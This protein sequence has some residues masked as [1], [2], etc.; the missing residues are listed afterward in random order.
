MTRSP[1]QTGADECESQ[2]PR[3][4]RDA[5][6]K[7]KR[8]A[9]EVADLV[10]LDPDNGLGDD[11][12]KHAYLSEIQQ[13][14]RPGRAIVFI[15]FSGRI[16]KH[17]ALVQRLHDRLGGEVLTMRTSASVPTAK[18]GYAPRV[19]WFTVVGPDA[20]L[21]ARAQAFAV[22]LSSM[23]RITAKIDRGGGGSLSGV[24]R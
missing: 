12:E 10:F 16:M 18:G 7:R 15:T 14:R 17:D 2:L 11:P 20:E 22:A 21:T 23:P 5:W 3:F 1:D 13:L 8:D 6:G 9:L 24:E 19:R 4:D